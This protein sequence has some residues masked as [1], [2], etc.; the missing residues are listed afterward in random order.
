MPQ[1]Q[2]HA[3][4][5][6]EHRFEQRA[7]DGRDRSFD[8]RRAVVAR[9]DADPV[10]QSGSQF[11]QLA[12]DRA[13]HLQRVV[14]VPHRDDSA[15]HFAA[16]FLKH[17]A[18]RLRPHRDTSN[19]SQPWRTRLACV[20]VRTHASRVS[21][22]DQHCFEVAERLALDVFRVRRR[23]AETGGSVNEQLGASFVKDVAAEDRLRV[24]DRLA[25]IARSQAEFLQ[26]AEIKLDDELTDVSADTRDFGDTRHAAQLR[27]QV[28]ILNVA[29]PAEIESRTFERVPKDLAGRHRIGRQSRRHAT[30]QCVAEQRQ[31]L[32]HASAC[33]RKAD[34]VVEDQV[35]QRVARF[36]RAAHDSHA[37]DPLQVPRESRGDLLIEFTR[38]VSRPIGKDEDLVFG[39]IRN[40]IHRRAT[41]R[42]HAT[43]RQHARGD[44]RDRAMPDR[45]FD[46]AFDHGA[47]FFK[48]FAGSLRSA[49]SHPAQQ[50]KTRR[51]TTSTGTAPPIEF[52]SAPVTG[53]IF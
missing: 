5:R 51:P 52:R 16:V 7:G 39:Q 3:Q 21:H 36:A 17:T 44:D 46:E 29:Q 49:V 33:G 18:P 30:R 23:R 50:M 9:D 26:L 15:D 32:L 35:Q 28:P 24:L 8:Q 53:Q 10:R 11:G 34:G 42:N 38:V 2:Q 25:D 41:D 37:V 14:A 1:H 27:T 45:Q 20:S 47:S 4:R 22:R 31:S 43:N 40:G 13:S 12:A 19:V 48:C 6:S